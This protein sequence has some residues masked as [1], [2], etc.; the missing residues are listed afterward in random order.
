MSGEVSRLPPL[1]TNAT[2]RS[3]QTHRNWK[4]PNA[5]IAGAISG[6]M[7]RLKIWTCPAPSTRADSISSPGIWL[8]KLCSR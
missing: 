4:M 3:F 8:M 2:S 6:S 5:A 1:N 7:I